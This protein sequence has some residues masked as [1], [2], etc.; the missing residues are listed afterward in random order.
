MASATP[1]TSP[2]TRRWLGKQAHPLRKWIFAAAAAGYAAGLC[3]IGQSWIIAHIIGRAAAEDGV[4]SGLMPLLGLLVAVW[5]ARSGLVWVK[6]WAGFR[7]GAGVRR[8]VRAALLE[9][10]VG[11]GPAGLARGS[12]GA[13]TSTLMEQVEGLHDFYAYFLPQMALALL[14]P[15]TI[16]FCVFPVAWAAGLILLFTAPLIP[17]FMVLVGM[18]AD[19]VS[20]RHFTALARMSGYF[21]DL[22]QG[23]ATLK[24]L[25]RSKDREDEITR[26]SATYRRRTMAVLRIAFLSSAVLEFFSALAIA[27][28][29]VYLGT[30]YLGYVDFCAYG[31]QLTLQNGLFILFLAPEF[32][33]PLRELG[34]RYHAR[35]TALGAAEEIL[36]VLKQAGEPAS[37]AAARRTSPPLGGPPRIGLHKVGITYRQRQQPALR[38]VS[39][40]VAP[41]EK[42]ALVGRSGAG[43]STLLNLILGFLCPDH[44]QIAIDGRPLSTIDPDFWRGQVAWISQRPML[45]SGTLRDNIC[46]GREPG[47]CRGQ[48]IKEAIRQARLDQFLTDL[49]RGLQTRLG[50]QGSRLSRGQAQ[51]VA[52]ARAWVKAAPLVV[53]DEPTAGLDRI[54]ENLVMEG[55]GQLARNRTVVMAT[56]RL[57]QLQWV[58]RIGVLDRGSLVEV[59]SYHDLLSRQGVFCRL[60]AGLADNHPGEGGV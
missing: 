58:D 31:R 14:I 27:M 2:D 16:L 56:H 48:Q 43:K 57:D 20:Q 32:Y 55:I 15:G 36:K 19:A 13:L 49:P 21:L 38:N 17:V 51:R 3:I 10:I 52:L 37:P 1:P 26:V 53:L 42:I 60:A 24:L 45:F 28:V 40:E 50:D 25:G 7:G 54:N 41:G 4:F 6:E 35:A 59:G 29:S 11:R 22:L 23:L 47:H 39:L 34:A 30:F 33:S 12:S 44:G 9:R 18:G 8:R 5:G 46:L